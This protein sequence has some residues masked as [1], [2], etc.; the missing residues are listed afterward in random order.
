MVVAHRVLSISDFPS[1]L[2][3]ARL[4]FTVYFF[5]YKKVRH[6]SF[7]HRRKLGQNLAHK[8]S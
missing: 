1:Y 5:G 6:V 3:A 2:L 4:T 7:S 8:V